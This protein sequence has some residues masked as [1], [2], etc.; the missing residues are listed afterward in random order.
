MQVLFTPMQSKDGKATEDVIAIAPVSAKKQN[1]AENPGSIVI[2]CSN[3]A[4]TT[5]LR[6]YLQQSANQMSAVA[7][8][9]EVRPG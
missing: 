5:E 6:R 7:G 3:S 9:L 1:A 8:V 4:K 2:R